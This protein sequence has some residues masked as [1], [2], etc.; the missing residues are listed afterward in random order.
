MRLAQKFTLALVVIIGLGLALRGYLDRQRAVDRH[1]HS[2]RAAQRDLGQVIG[3]AVQRIWL[4][5]GWESALEYL[6]DVEQLHGD[7]TIRWTWLEPQDRPEFRPRVSAERILSLMSPGQTE[8]ALDPPELPGHVVTYRILK[9]PGLPLGAVEFTRATDD[10]EAW[11]RSETQHMVT[12]NLFVVLV[13]ALVASILGR[14]LVGRPMQQLTAM[15]RRVGE[16]QFTIPA[17]IRQADE[18]GTLALEMNRMSENL[19]RAK[20]RADT[21]HALRRESEALLVHADRLASVGRLAASLI[22]DIGTPLNVIHGRATMVA[23]GEVAAADIPNAC[24][25]VADQADRIAKMIRG[26]LDFARRG[27]MERQPASLPRLTGEVEDLVGPVARKAKVRVVQA[28]EDLDLSAPLHLAS[29]RQVLTNLVINGVQAMPEGGTITLR[30]RAAKV[31]GK[32]WAVIEVEDQGTGISPEAKAHIF[33]AFYTTKPEGEG[34]GLGLHV[35]ARILAHHGGHIDV[36]S[37]VGR[38]TKM[39]VWLPRVEEEQS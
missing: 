10:Q 13:Y 1:T 34:T 23:E 36:D 22:H 39:Q 16:G 19:Q 11:I 28:H 20:E 26:L 24:R 6:D 7:T 15:A 17:E 12:S 37:E 5:D 4:R 29:M 2:V 3:A 33:D 21:E 30:T 25:K 18:I 38:G 35:C 32:E 27:N 14:R 31:D 8:V 9:L